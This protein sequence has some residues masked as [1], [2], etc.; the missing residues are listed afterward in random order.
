MRRSTVTVI[1]LTWSKLQPPACLLACGALCTSCELRLRPLHL[2]RTLRLL[3]LACLLAWFVPL[4]LSCSIA[5]V[6]LVVLSGINPQLYVQRGCGAGAGEVQRWCRRRWSNGF[7]TGTCAGNGVNTQH[8]TPIKTAR[9]RGRCT[10]RWSLHLLLYDVNY[11]LL[12]GCL[13]A[14]D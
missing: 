5:A 9:Q 12:P 3:H 2:A 4:A 13:Q 8:L 1:F 7:A 6:A 11:C 14:L 10:V